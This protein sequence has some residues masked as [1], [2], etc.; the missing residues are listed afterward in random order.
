MG[1][2]LRFAAALLLGAAA[3]SDADPE[4]TPD[5]AAEAE[6]EAAEAEAS[7]S[8]LA[9]L[10]Y[11]DYAEP[12][13]E[14]AERSRVVLRDPERAE[15]GYTLYTSIPHGIAE[16]VDAEGQV[17][18]SW[19]DSAEPRWTRAQLAPN[20][21]LLV[22]AQEPDRALLRL[23][24][25]GELLWRRVM[26]A[27]HDVELQQDG[28]ILTLTDGSELVPHV[29]RT[30]RTRTE[31]VSLLD[32]SGDGLEERS[33]FDLHAASPGLFGRRPPPT[34]GISAEKDLD[35][36]HLNSVHRIAP[37]ERTGEH[38]LY[39]PGNVLVSMRHQDA[40]AIFSWETERIL[41]AWGQGEIQV[42][43]EATMLPG[44]TVL[45]LDN[46]SMKRGWSRVVEVDPLTDEIVWEYRAPEPSDFFT[47]SRG[48][49]Q[50]LPGGNVLVGSSNSGEAF[51]V[52]R[53]GEVV[54]RF[55]NP[56]TDHQGRR[57]GIR[58]ER[59]SEAFV[60]AI[61]DGR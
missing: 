60:R 25:E 48:T 8:T 51:E 50:A 6:R 38:P 44:G 16:L 52:T 29:H 21:D 20:G 43:H 10:G 55:L 9:A 24:W 49:V 12:S 30:R 2:N 53:E 23:G 47:A 31:F 26:T 35:V 27:H 41:W 18:Q 37:T 14:P 33:I 11:T 13:D 7:L 1:V 45:L 46:G 17:V 15:P 42:Q 22:L 19:S 59:Y 36:Y 4:P 32:G 56:H 39:E 28:S 3:C 34:K 5:A 40:V 57:G 54:W 61:L 58:V